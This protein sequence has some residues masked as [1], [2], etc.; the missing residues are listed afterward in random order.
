MAGRPIKLIVALVL[1]AISTTVLSCYV[2][3]SSWMITRKPQPLKVAG[4]ALG[5]VHPYVP[6][7]V[8]YIDDQCRLIDEIGSP[9]TNLSVIRGGKVTIWNK[10]EMAATVDFGESFSPPGDVTLQPGWG[11]WRRVRMDAPVEGCEVSVS[12][13]GMDEGSSFISYSLPDTIITPPPD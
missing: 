8:V 1:V 12:C 3:V 10:S 11:V 13:A 5:P 9:V 7:W 2:P 6:D 4:L